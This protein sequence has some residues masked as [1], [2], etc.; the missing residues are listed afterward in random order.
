[1][2]LFLVPLISLA[3]VVS[4]RI[5]GNSFWPILPFI[6]GL[7]QFMWLNRVLLYMQSKRLGR[8]GGTI[9]GLNMTQLPWSMPLNLEQLMSHVLSLLS[10]QIVRF[11]L[12]KCMLWL[13]IY[14]ER[15]K[16]VADKLANY[17]VPLQK[18]FGG[19]DILPSVAAWFM[20][21]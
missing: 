14:T 1:M 13:L 3:Q 20:M 10:G 15:V 19:I 2:I 16:G 7:L 4:S 6:Q 18:T 17:V 9:C 5:A 12:I 11:Y 21:I 8:R